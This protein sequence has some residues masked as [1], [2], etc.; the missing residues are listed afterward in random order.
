[1]PFTLCHV[2]HIRILL[3]FIFCLNIIMFCCNEGVNSFLSEAPLGKRVNLVHF[4]GAYF[5]PETICDEIDMLILAGA[6]LL[7]GTD[8]HLRQNSSWMNKIKMCLRFSYRKMILNIL[9][10]FRELFIFSAVFVFS[11]LI[12]YFYAMCVFSGINHDWSLVTHTLSKGL[13]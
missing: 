10:L 2:R 13:I 12:L 3:I 7:T 5:D 6:A 1:M 9:D 8:G 11:S 4:K